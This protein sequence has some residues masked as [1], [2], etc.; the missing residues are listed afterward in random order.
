MLNLTQP[1]VMGILNVTPDS[2]FDGGAY[3]TSVATAVEQAARMIEAGATI[4][5]V[6]GASSRPGAEA[7]PLSVESVRV[8]PVVAAI[9]QQFPDILISVDTWRA[10][11]AAEAVAVGA[12]WINDISG[13]Q[14]DADL[15]PVVADLGVPYI[16]MHIKG[17]PDTMQQAPKYHDIGADVLQYFE[18]GIAQLRA[19]GVQDIIIDPGFGFGKTLTH[20]YELLN[21]M[22]VIQSAIGLPWLAGVSRKSMLYKLLQIKPEAALNATT[23]LHMIA[24]NQ[25]AKILRVHDVQ[26]AAEAIQIWTYNE[27]FVKNTRSNC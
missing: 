11:V 21:Q 22:S 25:G 5:D 18:Q 4:I 8:L 20:N 16:F 23:A 9:R 12:N 15:W 27:Q 6:G 7:V 14:F 13:G 1:I 24:L 2:F 19:L 10:K 3:S 26:A 17:T